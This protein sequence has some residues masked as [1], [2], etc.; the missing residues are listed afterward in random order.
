M[1]MEILKGEQGTAELGVNTILKQTN[2][3]FLQDRSCLTYHYWSTKMARII[4]FGS[5]SVDIGPGNV[6]NWQRF[7]RLPF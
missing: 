4:W 2:E 6:N 1:I 3:L 7:G 5:A